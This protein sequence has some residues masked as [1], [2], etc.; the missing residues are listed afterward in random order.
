V[1][2]V[3]RLL[4]VVGVCVAAAVIA[5]AAFDHSSAA[6]AKAAK[7]TVVHDLWFELVGQFMNSAPG[8]AP[9]THIHYGY[10]SW[11]QGVYAFGAPPRTRATAEYTFFADGKTS[12]AITNGPLLFITRTGTI[13]IYRDPSRNSDFSTPNT[14]R[15]GTRVLVATYRHQPIVSTLT[16]AISLISHDQITYTRPFQT[17]H[18]M[19]QLGRVGETFDEHYVGQNNMP[20][21]PSGYFIGYAASR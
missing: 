16:N 18:G 14:F 20:G 9:V 2:K 6:R 13:T 10:L 12:P 3:K 5:V 4:T 17:P 21:P 7:V 1:Q 8:V 15:D 11:I 19:V